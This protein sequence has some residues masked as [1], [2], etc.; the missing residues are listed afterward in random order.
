VHTRTEGGKFR[1]VGVLVGSSRALFGGIVPFAG[2]KGAS[3]QQ[4]Q[5]DLFSSKM[6]GWGELTL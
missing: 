6:R 3:T 2:A 5:V 4:V 1:E